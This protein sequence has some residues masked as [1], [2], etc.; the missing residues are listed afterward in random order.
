MANASLPPLIEQM[1]QPEFYPHDVQPPIR[2]MQTHV[3]YVLLT[4]D[5]AYKVKKSVDFGFLNY[6][7]LEKRQHF[8]EE[9]LRLNQR[10]AAALYLEVLP[11]AQQGDRFVLGADDSVVEYVVKMRQF[12]QSA[13][14]SHQFEQGELTEALL[15][16]LAAAIAEFHLKAKTNDYIRAF[17]TVEN[18]R[19]SIDENYE[20]TV[21]FIGGPQTQQQFDETK[22]FTD[23]FFCHPARPAPTAHGAGQ[24]SGLPW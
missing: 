24:N 1:L 17:G 19:Q 10:A 7:T 20:Q 2:L 11:I 13:L 21:G 18:V 5:F 4:G 14:L 22:A 8:C 3:S 23:E 6:S 15:Q 16:Q 9:E 12:P